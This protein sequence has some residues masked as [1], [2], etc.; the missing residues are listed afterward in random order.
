MEFKLEK[1]LKVE[2]K[3]D[4]LKEIVDNVGALIEANVDGVSD[5]W[6][7]ELSYTCD[8]WNAYEIDIN[9]LKLLQKH[10][11]LPIVNDIIKKIDE[12]DNVNKIILFSEE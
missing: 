12:I 9:C 10:F 6:F 1:I 7:Y 4:E 5:I 11:N 3:E 8:Y 2:M